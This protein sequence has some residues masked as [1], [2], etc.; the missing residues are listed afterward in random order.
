MIPV[1]G[2]QLLIFSDL[3]GTLLDHHTY[4]HAP[5]DDLMAQLTALHIPVIPCTSKTRAEV[6]TLRNELNHQQPFIIEN[7]AAVYVPKNYFNHDMADAVDRDDY[8]VKE[9]VERRA[10]WQS[11]LQALSSEL[12]NSFITFEQA[13]I[14]GIME[15]TGLARADAALA[16]QREYGEP[17][18]WNGTNEAYALFTKQMHASGANI[19]KGG[20]FVHVS[21]GTD[22]GHALRWLVAMYAKQ[23]PQQKIVTLALGDSHNDIAMFEVVDHAAIIKSPVQSAPQFQG[24]E[25]Q[26]IYT[27]EKYGPHGWVEAVSRVLEIYKIKI[28]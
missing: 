13:G 19:L 20:R 6:V 24:H 27:T 12:Q 15:M 17:V 5:A 28:N 10:H 8:Q 14:E 18:Q 25:G 4:S 21:G 7:G 2:I 9:F 3:D 23:Y 1:T 16:A 22:K 11:Q 26:D